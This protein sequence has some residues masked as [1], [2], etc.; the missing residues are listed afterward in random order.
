MVESKRRPTQKALEE[1]KGTLVALGVPEDELNTM[2]L[3]AAAG[4]QQFDGRLITLQEASERHAIPYN[5]LLAWVY[6]GTL[7]E[8]GREK[9]PARGGGK[10]L[11]SDEEV[12]HLKEHPPKR[13][14]RPR[15]KS[16]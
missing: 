13:T 10:V 7:Q 2:V 9:Y 8:Q 14:G 1:A 5:T 4:Q 16:Q 3:T 6:R 11:V 12:A 15:N